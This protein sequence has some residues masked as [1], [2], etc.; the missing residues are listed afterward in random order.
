ML[1]N[2]ER[3][4]RLEVGDAAALAL[5]SIPRRFSE[6]VAYPAGERGF[7]ARLHS[8]REQFQFRIGEAH[9]HDPAFDFALRQFRA[10]A[11]FSGFLL[12]HDSPL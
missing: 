1:P 4:L 7:L 6:R 2:R 9:R 10:S 11:F 12:A 8:L 5:C 3:Q